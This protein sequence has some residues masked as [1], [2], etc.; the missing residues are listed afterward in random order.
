[1]NVPLPDRTLVVATRTEVGPVVVLELADPD[2]APLPPV[3]P[4]AHLDLLLPQGVVRQYSLCGGTPGR[5]R[6]AVLHEPDGRGGSTAV[7]A[8]LTEGASV[9][10][11]GPRN[12]FAFDPGTA[13][14]LLVGGGIGLTPLVPMATAARSAGLDY[15]LH[16]AGHPER[17]PFVE[18]LLGE[19][20]EHVVLHRSGLEERLD[21]DAVLA[22]AAPDTVVYCCGPQRLLEAAEAAA[23]RHGLTLHTEH[24]VPETQ[25]AV[26][27][28]GDFEVEFTLSGVT[29]TVAPDRSIL[30]VAEENGIFVLSSCQEG[31]CGTCETPVI[32]GV[33]DHRDS[34]LTPAERERGDVMYVCVSR[35]A[36]PRLVVEL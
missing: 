2:G 4:G 14:V 16:V 13:P 15:T 12:H 3:E 35:A 18:E 7:H 17:L 24:F 23:A 6:L 36:C 26:L 29:A 25:G 1:M 21:L 10:I 32:D 31:T 22:A 28:E 34:I 19:H 5:W 30:E 20:G 8:G 27:W 11:A 9:G 33:V